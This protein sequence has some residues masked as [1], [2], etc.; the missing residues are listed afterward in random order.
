MDIEIDDADVE[1]MHAFIKR[2]C[3]EVGPGAPGSPQE[4]QRAE[5]VREEL[6][7]VADEVVV[8]EFTMAPRAFLGWIRISIGAFVLAIVFFS[9]VPWNPVLFSL[10]SVVVSSVGFIVMWEEFFNYK[11]FVDPLFKKKGSVN[12]IGRVNPSGEPPEKLL[13]FSGHH[14]SA[15]QFNLLYWFKYGYLVV[16]L[17]GILSMVFFIGLAAVRF[18]GVLLVGDLPWVQ[19]VANGLLYI[20]VPAIVLLWFFQGSAKDGGSVPGA[21]DNL[22]AVSVV[23]GLGRVLKRNP[24]LIP[25]NTEVRLVSFGCEEAGLRG[26]YRYVERHL[27]ELRRLDAEDFNMDGLMEPA[28]VQVIT[29]EDTTRTKHSPEVVAKMERAAEAAGV[30]CK[31]MKAP[32]VSGGTDA[33]AFSKARVKAADLSSMALREFVKFYHQPHDDWPKVNKKALE[34]ALRVAVAYIQLE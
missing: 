20:A 16:I 12:V 3:T 33:T 22:S 26:A 6:E 27:D 10:L 8:E 32:F 30:P 29:Q 17:V 19:Q 18:V 25:A 4:R 34:N 31:L 1:Y 23:L 13:I 14:D 7:K 15:Y 28:F 24:G 21:I 9:L 2:V 11:E 5:I